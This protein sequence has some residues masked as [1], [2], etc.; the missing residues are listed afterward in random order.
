MDLVQQFEKPLLS[1]VVLFVLR[2]VC[3]KHAQLCTAL[4]AWGLGPSVVNVIGETEMQRERLGP[5]ELFQS[6][7]AQDICIAVCHRKM[8]RRVRQAD[9]ALFKGGD[10][11]S[12][13]CV[14]G[15]VSCRSSW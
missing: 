3:I 12:H 5:L 6:V 2:Y 10:E 13:F 4:G 1:E 9:A 15:H 7:T 14:W 11:I 8:V